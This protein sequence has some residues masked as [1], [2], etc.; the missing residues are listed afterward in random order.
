M[1]TASPPA[2]PAALLARLAARR[3]S[4]GVGSAAAPLRSVHRLPAR[5]ARTAA[6]PDW[7]APPLTAALTQAGVAHL[8]S[9]QRETAEAARAGR[10]VVV[11]TGTASG[12][13]L[14]YL[15][16]V[17]SDLL[18]GTAAP[19]G[20]GATALYLAPTKAL[21]HDQFDRVGRLALPGLRVATYD[22]DTPPEERR[23]VREHAAYV[24][25]NPDLLHHSLLPG[26]E[27]WAPFL[28]SLRYVVVDECH[29]YRGVFGTHL[30]LV[31]RRLRR[32]AAR[33][34]REPTFV[35]AS[36]TVA[37]PSAHATRLVG[38][39]VESVTQDGSARGSV[40]VGLWE[41]PSR[42]S[43]DAEPAV[44][45]RRRSAVAESADLL[46]DLVTSGAQTVAFARS[47]VGAE[48]LAA[49]ARRRLAQ[50]GMDE[51]LVAAYRSG[52]LPEER[53]VLE[54]ALREGAV[55][56]MAATTALELGVDV[57][58]LD[59]VVLAGWPGTVASF[60]QQIGRAGRDGRDS[61]AVLV[62]A[63]DPL[64]TYLVSHP[65]AILERPVEAA[66]VDPDNPHVLGPHLACAAAEAPVTSADLD[67]G[68]FG[69]GAREALDRLVADG[70]LRRRPAGWF[71][72]RPDRPAD[73]LSLRGIGPIVRVVER[74]SGRVLGVVEESRADAT[75]H[76][77][78][79]YLHQGEPH[80]VTAFDREEG[81]ALVTAGDPGWSTQ[82]RSVSSFELGAVHDGA[83]H[84]DLSARVGEV[85]VHEQ[86]VSF[87]RVLPDGAVVGEHP[88]E[89]PVR[90]LR[91][92]GVWW[93]LPP[94]TLQTVIEDAAL[95]GALHAAEHAAI[96]MLP[97]VATADRWDVGGVSTVCHPDTGL[98][99]VL[100]YDG[101]PGGAGFAAR[102]Y[103]ALPTWLRATRDA[104]LDCGCP[105]GCPS[106]VQ[107]PKCGNGNEPL[108]KAGAIAVLDL[109][110]GRLGGA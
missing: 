48:V 10:H 28:R 11:S 73:A 100:V 68:I 3:S 102:G 83:E 1:C 72:A 55:R 95:P 61:V 30:S 93:T 44:T 60:W 21:A 34:R 70:V 25:T 90:T 71:W 32:V 46:A 12:K 5:T 37:D 97:L 38:M 104:V 58:G 8:W 81:V 19:T 105:S 101:Y 108:D 51:G 94:E 26:H 79:V 63:D 103:A 2:E 50:A 85:V 15:L 53:R 77:G 74:R 64:D 23:W 82:A 57:S 78:A 106:C 96:G 6:L 99:T 17:L 4:S 98:P 54:Q 45:A 39:P 67:S 35:L 65:E 88:L 84:E 20:R 42:T 16:P 31:L 92:V 86:V 7:L 62:A 49:S 109:V 110:L 40:T 41:P 24:L 43:T 107:S 56:G 66:V 14:G 69:V 52:Y 33:Y 89:A 22:G 76:V 87:L 27:R 36:A 91:T 47:R 80:V 59:A 13:T 9:H 18:D 75:V 29:V